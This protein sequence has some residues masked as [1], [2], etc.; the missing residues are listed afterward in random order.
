M[1][2]LN[3]GLTTLATF[4]PRNLFAFTVQLL[5]LP[6]EATRHLG[7]H[8]GVLSGIVRDDPVRAVGRHHYSEQAHL[9]VSGKAFDLDPRLPW[10]D[11]SVLHASESTRP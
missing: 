7:G 4:Q 3:T 1:I 2:A 9:V 6:T 8:R 10:A 11:S 5:N